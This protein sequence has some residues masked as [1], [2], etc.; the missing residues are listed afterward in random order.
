M[1]YIS[2]YTLHDHVACEV[3]RLFSNE[4]NKPWL[5]VVGDYAGYDIR[6]FDGDVRAE[7]KVET[8]S[9][10][11][12]CCAIERFSTDY[13]R[14]SGIDATE[15]NRWLQIALCPDDSDTSLSWKAIQ[16]DDVLKLRAIAKQ[17]GTEKHCGRNSICWIVPVPVLCQYAT[18]VFPFKTQFHEQ[19]IQSAGGPK[20]PR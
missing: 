8:S 10:R 3:A 9:S 7:I 13:N 4:Q 18:R 16:Y 12:G 1:S 2:R 20:W 14:P 11:T 5:V 19:L 17:Y 6:S 15:A